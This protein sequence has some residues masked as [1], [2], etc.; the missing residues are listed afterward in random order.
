MKRHI[1]TLLA[2]LVVGAMTP[3][4]AQDVTITN[5][6]I[7]VA[8]G[9]VIDRGSIVV[10]A[11]KIVS[12]AAG[13]PSAASGQ[14]ID[15][16]G[17]TAMPGFIDAHRHINTGPNEKAQMQA[18]LDACSTH[19]VRVALAVGLPSARPGRPDELDANLRAALLR[20]FPDRFHGVATFSS[21]HAAGLLAA[22]AACRKIAQGAFD[23]CVV[24]GVDS[25]L[26]PSSLTWLEEN[27]QL[28]GAGVLNNAWGFIPGE[29]AGAIILMER[30]SI[31]RLGLTP[32]AHLL[33]VGTAF[34][35][36]GI[37]S[38]SVCIGEGL[39]A[40]FRQAVAA[41]PS[42]AKVTDMFCDMN[43]ETYRANEFG[44]ACLRTKEWFE[45]PSD[46]VAPADCWGD[47]S[48]AS[49]PLGVLLAAT[50]FAKTDSKGA[51]AMVW[52]SSESGERAAAV[53]QAASV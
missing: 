17:M 7:V 53:L 39:T 52:A 38:R 26:A 18:Q 29:A 50:T 31:D 19:G 15:A 25:Y 51:Y 4:F 42:G 43:G 6:R 20:H 44:F 3:L 41:V 24:A 2:C 11:G 1:W 49:G 32:L 47:I 45:S 37:K 33:S 5:A 13:A 30:G 9:T 10:R 21:G 36:N 48:A 46:F 14:T 23:A 27:E 40:A 16:K 12:V 28:H 22:D 8:N 35:P 34:E